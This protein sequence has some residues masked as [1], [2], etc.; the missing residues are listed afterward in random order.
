M[1]LIVIGVFDGETHLTI[2]LKKSRF[3]RYQPVNNSNAVRI[4][5]DDRNLENQKLRI[6]RENCDL[7]LQILSPDSVGVNKIRYFSFSYNIIIFP[8]QL[9]SI[10]AFAEMTLFPNIDSFCSFDQTKIICCR[11][12]VK[13]WMNMNFLC[14]QRDPSDM[15][16]KRWVQVLT[17][18]FNN[19]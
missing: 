8:R 4:T 12:F 6:L 16:P 10:N 19:Y 11:S 13:I 14:S 17:R 2:T 9:Y 3:S 1:N 15:F 18:F 5:R 7:F